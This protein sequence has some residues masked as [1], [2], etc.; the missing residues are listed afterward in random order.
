MLYENGHK[1]SDEVRAKIAATRT[2][3]RAHK[4]QWILEHKEAQFK[5]ML[6]PINGNGDVP[7]EEVLTGLHPNPHHITLRSL[8]H[9][10]S[11]VDHLDGIIAAAE[12]AKL[13]ILEAEV[14][15]RRVLDGPA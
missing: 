3:T 9:L 13:K 14:E 8:P 4:E 7:A 12:L 10:Q 1:Q 2:A 15:Y 5:A 11:T 6:S